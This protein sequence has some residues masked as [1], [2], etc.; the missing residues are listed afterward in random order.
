M[1]DEK[2][3]LKLETVKEVILAQ[4]DK[5]GEGLIAKKAHV[6]E[7]RAEMWREARR[8]ISDFDDIADLTIFA[9]DV[10][11]TEV[12]YVKASEDIKKLSKM[13]GSPYFARIDFCEEGYEDIEEIYIGRQSL[14]DEDAKI[15]HVYDWRAPI[16][17]LYYDYGI[18]DASFSVPKTGVSIRGV[19]QL[20]RQYQIEKGKLLYLFDNDIAI[21]DDILR[22]ALS[23]ASDATIKTIINTIQADQNRAIRAESGDILV[24]GPAG[25][26]KT[27][28]GLHRLAY[29]LYLHRDSLTSAKVRI[30]SPSSIFSSYIAG[31]IPELGEEDV[32][33]QDFPS[34]IREIS[35]R[36]FRGP[37]QQ[38]EHI[39]ENPEDL[40]T[41]WLTLKYSSAFLDGLE[42]AIATYSPVFEDVYFYKD[43]ICDAS[44]L[45]SLYQ[46]RTAMGTLA[47][48]TERILF[49]IHQSYAE[50]YKNNFKD[51]MKLFNDIYQDD[52]SDQEIQAKF[53]EEKNIAII[54]LKNRMLPRATKLF[55]KY[56]RKQA[57]VHGLPFSFTKDAL[58]MERLYYEDALSLVYVDLLTGRISGDKSIKH[59]LLDEAQDL[60][61]LHHR[62]LRR[63]YPTSR[64]TILGDVNQALYSE[65][66]IT[67][68]EDLIGLY[69]QAEVI[70]LTKS[71]RSTYEI[72]SFAGKIIGQDE[73]NTFVR[74]GD[75]PKI[76]V[77]QD[78]ANAVADILATLPS[79]YNTV[80]I[81]LPTIKEAKDF[82]EKLQAVCSE[83]S[84]PLRLIA[85]EEQDF[86]PGIMVMAAPFV[87]GLEFDAVIYPSYEK[88]SADFRRKKLSYLICTR[89]L[90]R[91]YL[92]QNRLVD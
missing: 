77:R 33:N 18:G 67:K 63:L 61:I 52:L 60:S 73:P 11:R 3:S 39:T 9:D 38:I 55:E 15:F 31:I 80:G 68:I 30:F 26:G 25:S 45:E 32:D 75:A 28:V 34:L 90:H 62:I 6:L 89:A 10:E 53:D 24:Y 81:L 4:I 64:F 74:H 82:Y 72:M 7:T 59:I 70:P 71:Y 16:S 8:A 35:R 27:S 13:L 46:D 79:D 22:H 83:I 44:R 1:H 57:K 23:K 5:L 84:R 2:E 66:N 41:Q 56:L 19:I 86:I 50:Y 47:S 65:I 78:T 29:L 17:S 58:R 37:Y 88:T 14:F 76:I 49:Y 69:P 21:E 12:Q 92:I 40:R 48:K 42:K 87:K 20:K 54:D 51:V 91:L 43:K 36:Q 85:G